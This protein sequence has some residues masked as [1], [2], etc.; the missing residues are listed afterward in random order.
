MNVADQLPKVHVLIADNRVV[1]ILKEMSVP[2]MAEVVSHSVTCE[3]TP[4][5][6]RKTR[7]AASQE[8]VSMI[9]H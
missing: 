3:E 9:G 2:K 8:E 1:P 7:G 4:H 5:E 6:C